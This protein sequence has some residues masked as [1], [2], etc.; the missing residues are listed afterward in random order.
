ME[1]Q[2]N[3]TSGKHQRSASNAPNDKRQKMTTPS[4]LA[5]PFQNEGVLAA[6][7]KLTQL[8]E[9]HP[10]FHFKLERMLEEVFNTLEPEVSAAIRKEN[11]EDSCPIFE[12]SNDE[13]KLVFG[14]VGEKQYGFVA[15][16]S[17]RFHH[18]YLDTFG[19]ETL[20]SIKSAAVFPSGAKLCLDTEGLS[21]NT[22]AHAGSLFQ[23]ATSDGK[24][25]VLKW[26]EDSGYELDNILDEDGIADVALNGHLEVAKYLRKLGVSCNEDTCSNAAM[27]GHLEL[28]K[29]CRANQ[30]PWNEDTCSY[31]AFSGQLKL[32]K[33]ARTNQ[34]PWNLE[35]CS[36][37]AKNGHLELLK[38]CKMNQCPWNEDTC[39]Y[40]AMNGHLELL[41]WCRA[42]RCPWDERTCIYAAKNGRLELLKWCRVNQC[43]W[44]DEYTC[45]HAATNGHLELLKWCRVNQCPWNEDTCSQAA[46]NGHLELLKW[47]RLNGCP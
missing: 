12:L 10:Q 31:A 29:W 36:R 44:E 46:M 2:N 30:C 6:M 20:T 22:R 32:L 25:A 38:W 45:R 34:C 42:N 37:A 3:T 14:Y 8:V 26:G 15:Y 1:D 9:H 40:A 16:V 7:N 21:Y 41:K 19:G 18:V 33:W 27:N 28:L 17:D 5:T 35:T 13:L 23:A 47:A 11:N 4:C 43:P 24:L 39:S